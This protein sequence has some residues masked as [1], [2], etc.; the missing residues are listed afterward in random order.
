[1]AR[2][3]NEE[4]KMKLT[5][6]GTEYDI[7]AGADLEGAD[8][9]WVNLR[10]VDLE[11][12]DLSNADLR[13]A[14]LRDANL[15]KVEFR[16]ANLQGANLEG[17]DLT[18]ADLRKAYLEGALFTRAKLSGAMLREV[19]VAGKCLLHVTPES[20]EI[21]LI[22]SE[23]LKAL[24]EHLRQGAAEE[25]R[26]EHDWQERD[27]LGVINRI[28]AIERHHEKYGKDLNSKHM[29]AIAANAMIVWWHQEVKKDGN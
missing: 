19:D 23:F 1:M 15:K 26:K 25:G 12:A 20:R 17:A 10:G 8:L 28:F 14:D 2:I 27:A 11:G 18:L 9:R 3:M 22:N 21:S 29:L 4:Y 6:N 16:R 24:N 5:L 7:K 13:G